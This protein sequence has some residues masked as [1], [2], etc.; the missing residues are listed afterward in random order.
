[1]LNCAIILACLLQGVGDV[2]LKE[3]VRIVGIK[4]EMAVA[5]TVIDSIYRMHGQELVI[6]SAVEG[7]HSKISRHYL[8]YAIDTRTFYFDQDALPDVQ[9]DIQNALGDDFYIEHEGNHFHIQFNPKQL[10]TIE[11]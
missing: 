8:G 6:T 7:K 3:G 4:P 11:G 10:T 1:M 9:R 5:I 2:K